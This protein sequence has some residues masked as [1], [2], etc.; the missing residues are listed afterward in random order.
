MPA[1]FNTLGGPFDARTA[2]GRYPIFRLGTATASNYFRPVGGTPTLTTVAPTFAANPEFYLDLNE[3]GMASP[4]MARANSF[5]SI[6]YDVTKQVTAFADFS[7][8]KADSTMV[9]QPLALNAPTTDKLAVMALDN[10]YNP[11]GSRF[12]S[13][14]GAPNLDG[15]PRLTGAPRTVSLVSVTLPD[16]GVEKISTT[17]DVVRFAAGFKGKL[18]DTWTWESSGFYNRVKGEDKAF[19][20]VRES[21]LQ[22]ALAAP[23]PPPTI[24]SATRSRCRTVPS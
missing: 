16:L 7:Y 8:Y 5:F 21:K 17:A 23:T 19:P 9:R 2:R 4:R 22:A 24:P 1:P 13:A 14:T 3:F 12:Y 15:T 20:D 6:E 11:Y 18:G 10:P